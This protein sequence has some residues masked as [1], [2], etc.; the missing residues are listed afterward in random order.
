MRHLAAAAINNWLASLPD[1]PPK[2]EVG[3]PAPQ[4]TIISSALREDALGLLYSAQIT[5]LDALQGISS[6]Y[7]SWGIVKLYYSSFY[8]VRSLLAANSVSIF[9]INN[10][11]YSLIVH[12]G[13]KIRKE[14]G[15]THKV[16]WNVLINNFSHSVLLGQIDAFPA[17]TWLMNLR[18]TA[19]YR[20]AKFPDP[21]VPDCLSTLD[22]L[23]LEKAIRTYSEDTSML[24]T[25]DPDHAVVA[26]PLE[27]IRKT[28]VTLDRLGY[29]LDDTDIEYLKECY[30]RIGVGEYM[31]S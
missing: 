26:F 2:K 5:F 24:Y 28:R 29:K 9:Y 31:I 13:H 30:K 20:T 10:K 3:L 16:V 1:N 6:G 23:G 19:N 18:E 22:T 25:F 17:Q 11:P 21:M 15:L 12:P 4:S 7:F 27:C 14:N 8:A